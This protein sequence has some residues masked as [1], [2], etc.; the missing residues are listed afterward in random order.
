MVGVLE[1]L[2][3]FVFRSRVKAFAGIPGPR[4]LFPFGTALAFLGRH[5]W[6]VCADYAVRY[7]GLTLIWLGGSP[8][9]VLNDPDLIGEV[10]EGRNASFYKEDPRQA[11]APVITP[12]CLFI[13]NG[14]DH[15]RRRAAHPFSMTGFDDWLD[16]RVGVLRSSVEAGI[17]RLSAAS[18]L[19]PL[20]LTSALQRLSFD[21]FA[22]TVF[23]ATFGDDAYAEFDYLGRVGDRRMQR[24]RPFLSLP[25]WPRFYR[26]RRSWYNRI[27]KL[28][29]AAEQDPDP[30]RGDLPSVLVRRGVSV[31]GD[32]FRALLANVFYGGV[33]SVT[34]CLVTTLHLLSQHLDVARALSDEAIALF[35]RARPFD[36]AALEACPLLDAV[37]REA[38][39]YETPVPLLARNVQTTAAVELGGRSIPA[40][41]V[42][43]LTSWALHR[44][45]AHWQEP[46]RFDP[47]RWADGGASANPMG[48]GYYFPFGRGPRAC[49]GMPF[50]LFYL[51]LALAACAAH[52]DWKIDSDYP[53]Q[54]SFFF[55]VRMP[56]GVR[57]RAVR[58]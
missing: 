24:P 31:C 55:G 49:I 7:G 3:R 1:A 11:L 51:K 36:R 33:Y 45:P 50:A 57:G 28:L 29:T 38:L 47:S 22:T 30:R 54:Q 53:A 2:F 48:S 58:R 6:E 18:A 56:V 44:S 52:A 25:G 43:F 32:E 35:G 10:L 41:T 14:A 42:L 9:L 4:P 34:S 46:D 27:D 19:G 8:V 12:S 15:T 37:L 13:S 17:E 16:T 39:R 5:P 40:N 20:D 26:D 23:G 21:A